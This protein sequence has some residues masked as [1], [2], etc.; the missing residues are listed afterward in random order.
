M[1]LTKKQ[2]NKENKETKKQRNKETKKEIAR[3]QYS[4]PYRG[5]GNNYIAVHYMVKPTCP[6]VTGEHQNKSELP[7]TCAV[8]VTQSNVLICGAE[9]AEAID[10]RALNRRTR[11]LLR[12]RNITKLAGVYFRSKKIAQEL[13]ISLLR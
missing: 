7:Y 12:H 13:P 6:V 4:V 10:D 11:I 8:D 5:R 3:K 2:R 1:L 9:L